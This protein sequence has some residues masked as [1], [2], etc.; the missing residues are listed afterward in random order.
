[1][2]MV[3]ACSS[4]A[5]TQSVGTEGDVAET[6]SCIIEETVCAETA[7]VETVPVEA[8]IP[9]FSSEITF[10][11]VYI[12]DGEH[13]PYALYSPSLQQDVEIPII[14]FLHGRGERNAT[15]SWF[16]SVGMPQIMNDWYLEGFS[17]YVICPQLYGSWNCDSWNNRVAAG[18]VMDL[19]DQVTQDYAVKTDS[20]FLVGFSSGGMG[21]MKMAELYPDY[22]SKLVVM[23]APA[24]GIESMKSIKI[25]TIGISEMEVSYNSFMKQAFPAVF[26][27]N[28][29]RF[30]PV[31]HAEVP[32]AAFND[33]VDGNN[34]SDLVEWL[35]E[36]EFVWESE[37]IEEEIQD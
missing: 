26:G 23:S 22:F 25:P 13:M 36:D 3:A 12:A 6:E 31:K 7:C 8:E 10:S 4:D 21:A 29:V 24:S 11:G 1:M 14:V 19:L 17:A 28:S 20:I 15:E 34:R 5:A 2:L 27:E 16:M 33:D 37:P 9:L 35:L 18:Y 32:S 30:Y